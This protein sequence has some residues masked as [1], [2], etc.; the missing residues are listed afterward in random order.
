[1]NY[2]H[3]TTLSNGDPAPFF[4]T[5]AADANENGANIF[6]T[7]KA[8]LPLSTTASVPP[9]DNC[10]YYGR[11]P[12]SPRPFIIN[13]WLRN[14]LQCKLQ[15]SAASDLA[16]SFKCEFHPSLLLDPRNLPIL[17]IF[18]KQNLAFEFHCVLSCEPCLSATVLYPSFILTHPTFGFC[19]TAWFF[20]WLGH[21]RFMHRWGGT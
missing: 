1:L 16:V 7:S 20:F 12:K 6:L 18:A 13:A 19:F 5:S 21:H 15:F 9:V 3:V 10:D 8:S 4:C 14:E 17:Y 11:N 2:H